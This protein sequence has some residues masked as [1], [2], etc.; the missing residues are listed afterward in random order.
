MLI[1]RTSGWPEAGGRDPACSLHQV[2]WEP[3]AHF[4]GVDLLKSLGVSLFQ[5]MPIATTHNNI[6]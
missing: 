4:G 3:M 5:T 2:A 6:S 1:R